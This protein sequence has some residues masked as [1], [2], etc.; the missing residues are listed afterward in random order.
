VGRESGSC[1]RVLA[2][3]PDM[4]EAL[5]Q[6]AEILKME[7]QVTEGSARDTLVKCEKVLQRIHSVRTIELL[8]Y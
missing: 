1:E 6:S 2:G 4:V 7:F 5:Q 8:L 3:S